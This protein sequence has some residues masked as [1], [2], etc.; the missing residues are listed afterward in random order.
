MYIIRK[1]RS[2]TWIRGGSLPPMTQVCHPE[3][4]V[5]SCLLAGAATWR[6]TR[7]ELVELGVFQIK[8]ACKHIVQT[9]DLAAAHRI[10][11]AGN[12]KRAA[13]EGTDPSCCKM[14]VDDAVDFVGAGRGLI[15]ALAEN[16]HDLFMA[17]PQGA[18]PVNQRPVKTRYVDRIRISCMQGFI[19]AL[20]MLEVGVIQRAALVNLCQ[21]VIEKRNVTSRL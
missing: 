21:Q 7:N 6:L 18:K 9:T 10:G 14:A 12:R 11:L 8:V 15:H 16:G 1:L 5:G 13:A 20:N 2:L 3:N 19:K 17:H 4:V